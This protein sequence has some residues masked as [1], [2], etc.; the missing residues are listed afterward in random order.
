MNR[1]SQ[2]ASSSSSLLRRL[3]AS[4]LAALLALTTAFAPA[5]LAAQD[6]D[7][8]EEKVTEFT[9]DNGLHFIIIERDV[10]PVASFLTY[11]KV[12]GVDEPVG[13]TG[14]AHIFE[15]MAF[16]GTDV[17]GTT[18]W[19]AER[20][21]I[22]RM[23]RAYNAWF[24]ASVDPAADSAAVRALRETFEQAQEEAG[25]FVVNNEFSQIVDRSGGVG[26]NAFTSSDETAYFYSLPQN[27]AELWFNLESARFRTPVFREFYIEKD[28]VMEE[29]RMRTDSN[30][31]G[32]LVE[33]FLKEAYTVH[34]Y[35]N[36]VV[37]WAEDIQSTTIEDARAFYR[38]YY[39]P[40]NM[41]IAIAGDVDPDEMRRLAELYFGDMP[42]GEPVPEPGKPEPPQSEERRFIMSEPS[43]PIWL[44]GYHT[45][46]STHPDYPALTL[47]GDIISS[48]RTSR[49]YRELVEETRMA[50][51]VQAL[52]GFP[53]TRY[54]SMFMTLAVPNQGV[55][56]LEIEQAIDRQ[57]EQVK[58]GAITREELERAITNRRANIVRGL[59]SNS[60]LAL[61]AATA[62]ALEGDWRTLFT[63]LEDFSNVTLDDLVRVAE[64][65]LRVEN[66][67]V[68]IIEN[69][70]QSAASP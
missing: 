20:E 31:V 61:N 67:T 39:V 46:S 49:L 28:V 11:V 63:Q 66:R 69:A 53:G 40:S 51:A 7:A 25:A 57:I 64:T 2:P 9:L 35:G 16:K 59:N 70:A 30:P 12:G 19:Q 62:H 56:V 24:A 54:P 32:R 1:L 6:L 47:L 17:I 4:A 52:N 15:H 38:T 27:K 18:D 36:P 22:D 3:S 37:G 5:P 43:Q 58:Q 34:P 65:Y 29:R 14:I 23:D 45:V 33:R 8:F 26:M 48:G 55:D 41:T 68:G 21:A 42:A 13:N 44:A 60:G 50:L 10:A